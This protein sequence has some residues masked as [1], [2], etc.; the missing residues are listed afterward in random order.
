MIQRWFEGVHWDLSMELR[1]I[2]VT[3]GILTAATLEAL[4]RAPTARE[5]CRRAFRNISEINLN[6]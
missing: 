2:R 4:E 1:S 5:D 6:V 3:G